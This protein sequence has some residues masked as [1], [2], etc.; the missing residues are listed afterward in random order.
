MTHAIERL[1]EWHLTAQDEA[2]IAA[3]LA[4]CFTTDFGGR[5]FFCHH[6]HLRLVVR[7]DGIIGH[8]AL[9]L[10]S[11][12][13]DGRQV[14][15]AGLAEVA[16][17]PGHRGQGIAASLLQV[18]IAEAKASPAEYL[19]LFGVAGIYAAA[20]FRRVANPLTCVEVDGTRV[21]TAGDDDLMVLALRDAP[22]PEGPVDLRGPVF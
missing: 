12:V 10:R 3:L 11:I 6:H 9:V 13:L 5:S 17:D 15:V 7:G 16:T 18:A 20:G 19:L 2:A 14:T 1:A 8:M 22:W 4:R 21:G